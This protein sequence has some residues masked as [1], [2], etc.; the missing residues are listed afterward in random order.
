MASNVHHPKIED[1][2]HYQG[3]AEETK[4]AGSEQDEDKDHKKGIQDPDK[5]Q[6]E[7]VNKYDRQFKESDGF[8]YDYWPVTMNWLGLGQRVH[9][10]K[11][12][13]YAEQVKEA[14]DFAIRKQ[15]EKEANLE[16]DK[17]LIATCFR[18]FLY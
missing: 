12:T 2:F 11:D 14:L 9:L 5:Y 18:P 1:S 3:S 10:E 6:E 7:L 8:E 15:N 17:I 16:V 13:V 4:I